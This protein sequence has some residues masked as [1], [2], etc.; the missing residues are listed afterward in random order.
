MHFELIE[1]GSS[2]AA[3]SQGVGVRVHG[4]ATRALR[5][6]SLRLYARS[7]FGASSFAYPIFLDQSLA[8]YYRLIL[9]NS[10]N[11]FGYAM[12]RDAA[13]QAIV[14]PLGFDTQAY[15]PAALFINGEFWGIHNIRERFDKYYLGEVYGVDRDNIDL[16]E[17]YGVVEEGDNLHYVALLNF[18]RSNGAAGEV[19][20]RHIETQMDVNN[21]ADYQISQ[22]FAR[23]TDWPGNNIAYWRLRTN[24]YQP[25]DPGQTR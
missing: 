20:Y 24:A 17:D 23:N 18:I 15:R 10:G 6:K 19:Q 22:I 13:I 21:Y 9:R 14:A 12:F 2:I 16:L 3:L 7:S 25:G 11:D 4:N 1:P 5:M 8:A